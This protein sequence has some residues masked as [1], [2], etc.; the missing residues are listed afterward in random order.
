MKQR[1]QVHPLPRA[2]SL[3]E[4]KI[5]QTR[6]N[7]RRKRKGKKERRKESTEGRKENE[8]RKKD[9]VKMKKVCSAA[10]AS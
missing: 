6:W 10:R 5:M 3:T 1:R 8:S 4:G 9:M 7:N 2:K